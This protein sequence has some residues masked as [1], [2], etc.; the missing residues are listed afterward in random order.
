MQEHE[1]WMEAET[2]ATNNYGRQLSLDDLEKEIINRRAKV[3]EFVQQFDNRVKHLSHDEQWDPSKYLVSEKADGNRCFVLCTC[4][5]SVW[6][7]RPRIKPLY[8]KDREVN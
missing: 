8:S 5:G 1:K 7:L 6:C 3:S 2:T 4:D